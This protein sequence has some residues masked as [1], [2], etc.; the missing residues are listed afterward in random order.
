MDIKAARKKLIVK[1]AMCLA[2][3][4]GFIGIC[5][6]L[7]GILGE[8]NEKNDWLRNDITSLEGKIEGLSKKA[9]EFSDAVKTWKSMDEETRKLEGLRI[10]LAKELLDKYE[11]E[12]YFSE[13]TTSF[14][15]PEEL[16]EGLTSDM[17]AVISSSVTMDFKGLTDQHVLECLGRMMSDFPGYIQITSLSM[18]RSGVITK[19]T[20][21]KIAAG[22][23]LGLVDVK[24]K[25][26]WRDLTF[27]GNNNE[28]AEGGSNDTPPSSEAEGEAP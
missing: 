4:G 27:K 26:L 1:S 7:H 28:N 8:M 17:V 14:S 22:E 5:L 20:L 23:K 24:L 6:Y 10:T 16:S 2:I 9:L 13:V 15:K 21:Q 11:K 18:N 12:C 19:E 25:F 3:L